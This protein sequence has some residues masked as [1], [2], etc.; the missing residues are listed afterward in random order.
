MVFY[1]NKLGYLVT[2]TEEFISNE[3]H[4]QIIRN[5]QELIISQGEIVI[6]Y[7]FF[8]ALDTNTFK[9]VENEIPIS[10]SCS[11]KSLNEEIL[12]K[13]CL[14][15]NYL[16]TCNTTV[17]DDVYNCWILIYAISLWYQDERDKVYLFQYLINIIYKIKEPL[18]QIF[19]LLLLSLSNYGDELMVLKIYEKLIEIGI[20]P[21]Y[22]MYLNQLKALSKR[23]E[24]CCKYRLSDR[25]SIFNHI[26]NEEVIL[27]KRSIKNEENQLLEDIVFYKEESCH[28]CKTR[29]DLEKVM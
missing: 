6:Y 21:N 23:N 26:Q 20:K 16:I 19:E 15:N 9:P 2:E 11:L 3:R 4:K 18:N 10:L 7:H 22:S 5:G 25:I 14:D 13:T 17:K 28:E 8:P 12:Q 24:E 29:I 1:V 27:R